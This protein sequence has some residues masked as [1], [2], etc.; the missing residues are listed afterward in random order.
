MAEINFQ[1]NINDL[2]EK[3]I[4]KLILKYALPNI[5]GMVLFASYFFIIQIFIARF[6]GLGVDAVGAVGICIPVMLISLSFSMLTGIGAAS[7]ISIYL[8]KGD[9]KTS[10]YLLGNTITISVIIS[11]VLTLVFLLF[12]EQILQIIGTTEENYKFVK[13][14]LVIFVPNTIFVILSTTTGHLI[15]ASGHPKKAMM[16]VILGLGTNALL[17]PT[18]SF[19]LKDAILG[20]AIALVV[21]L[22]IPLIPSLTHFL[23]KDATL[24]LE[25]HTLKLKTHILNLIFKIGFS[26]FLISFSVSFVGIIMNNRLGIYGGAFAINAY[27]ISNLLLAFFTFNLSG[28]TQGV[29]PIIGYNFGAG[30]LDRVFKTVK[31][32][33]IIAVITGIVGLFV[34]CFC[35][36]W[37]VKML[38]TGNKPVEEEAIRCLG[39]IMLGLPLAG[40]HLV[41]TSFFQS[42]GS[43]GKAFILSIARQWVIFIPMIFILP[44]FWQTQG[45]WY[46]VPFTEVL[47]VILAITIFINQL[48]ILKKQKH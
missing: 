22:F 3:S 13:K 19:M 9:K 26:P 29:Q 4:G 39:V 27:T 11:L 12:F 23:K 10:E 15:R 24:K 17:V 42:I 7:Q 38:S 20:V 5:I 35:P 2:K 32:T 28:L 21:S 43:A 37:F 48:R 36:H 40:L 18:L 46:S 25:M 47:S 41:F 33:G 6:S 8:G 45:I 16:L 14:F 30:N 34:G 31:I 1:N 44:L